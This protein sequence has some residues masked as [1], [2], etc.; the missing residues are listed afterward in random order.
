MQITMNKISRKGIYLLTTGLVL[1][2]LTACSSD[3]DSY[4]VPGSENFTRDMFV[5]EW[6]EPAG[7]GTYNVGFYQEDG[8]LPFTTISATKSNWEYSNSDGYWDF[9]DGKLTVITDHSNAG[10][11]NT[12]T[13]AVYRAIKL[14]KYEIQVSSLDL[15][16]IA[17][18]YR[19]VDTYQMNVG[20]SRQAIINDN[21]F[22]PQEYSSMSYH[23]AS[24]DNNGKIEARH[25]GTTYILIKSSI[26]T[27]V[28]RVVVN[29]SENVFNDALQSMGMPVQ[30]I[31]KEYGQTYAEAEDE[32]DNRKTIRRYFLP[33]EKVRYIKMR[34]DTDG[35]VE[36]IEQYFSNNITSDEVRES[37]NRKYDFQYSEDDGNGR[38]DWYI[39]SWQCRKVAVGYSEI[40]HNLFMYFLSSGND[41]EKYDRFFYEVMNTNASLWLVAYYMG[42]TLTYEDY[43]NNSFIISEYYPFKFVEV[44]ADEQGYVN[45]A[46]L[47][48]ADGITFQD[49]EYYVKR[50]YLPTMSAHIYISPEATYH[51]GYSEDNDGYLQFFQYD[52]RKTK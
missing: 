12:N 5:G 8:S 28:I 11:L 33:D 24:V 51:L 40:D 41:L 22:V 4:Y 10:L 38:I 34:L 14:T 47:Y 15:D 16:N 26:G 17:G 44:V 6:F 13:K 43:V 35:Y 3:D 29:D 39:A 37:L 9:S 1:V 25:L 42:Y 48:F 36:Y 50:Y 31:T 52:K 18:D 45:R 32:D 46:N 30:T 27:A 21:E 23:I 19:I 49:V 20:E 7:E 2:L